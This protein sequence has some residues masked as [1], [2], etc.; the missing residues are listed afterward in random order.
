MLALTN[1]WAQVNS[2]Y[3]PVLSRQSRPTREVCLDDLGP[4]FAVL[5]YGSEQ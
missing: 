1:G 2:K 5:G 3:L 4:H